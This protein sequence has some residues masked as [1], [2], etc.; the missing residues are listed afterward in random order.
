MACIYFVLWIPHLWSGGGEDWANI[1]NVGSSTRP[2]LWA[3]FIDAVKSNPWLGYGWN[4]T[5]LAHI[6]MAVTH[7]P[8]NEYFQSAHNVILDL[9]IW[10]GVPI[11]LIVAVYCA[12]W[13]VTRWRLAKD[14]EDCVLWLFLLVVINHSFLELPLQYAYFLLPVGLI[15]GLLDARMGRKVVLWLDWKVNWV[16]WFIATTM[17][18][19]LVRDYS[20][21]ERMYSRLRYQWAGIQVGEIKAP[22]V[23]LLTQWHDF[24]KISQFDS[25]KIPSEDEIELMRQTAYLYPNTGFFQLLAIGWARRGEPEKAAQTLDTMCS[26]LTPA[27]CGSVQVFWVNRAKYDEVVA[28]VPWPRNR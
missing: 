28:T 20:E 4:Q 13:M 2:A 5:G 21:I 19:L 6:H 11:G 7:P 15:I 26:I 14:H 17:V 22:E 1:A 16:L 23:T 24:Y 3:L 25:G 12:W 10:C 27:L 8:L 18:V 9:V